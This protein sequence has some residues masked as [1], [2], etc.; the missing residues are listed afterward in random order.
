[1]DRTVILY[2]AATLDGYIATQD[3]DLKFLESVE[4]EGE[5]YGYGKFIKNVDAVIVGRKTYDKVL[6]MG[7]DFPHAEKESYIITRTP[8]PDIGNIRF[9]TGEVKE[10]VLKLKSEPG[11]NIFV[12]GGSEI[13]HLLMSENLIDEYI[14]SIIPVLLG[15]GIRLFRDGRPQE[16]LRLISSTAFES[17]LVQLHY[18]K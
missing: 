10:L 6:S 1:M 16:D 15:D 7:F 17:G 11:N 2:I 12:D 13:V 3:G 8:R 5:D 9:Y 18:T 14:I 4:R